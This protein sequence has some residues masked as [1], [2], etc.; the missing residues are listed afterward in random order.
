[1]SAGEWRKF[2]LDSIRLIT[3]FYYVVVAVV[4]SPMNKS[5]LLII[6]CIV[7]IVVATEL[8]ANDVLEKVM[9]RTKG[10]DHS[11]PQSIHVKDLKKKII[12]E[13]KIEN[14]NLLP[15]F[16]VNDFNPIGSDIEAN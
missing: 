4:L 9:N 2:T 6:L 1:M 7:R 11:F 15:R 14:I 12:Y 8:S 13:V 16:N 5:I 3:L 10:I